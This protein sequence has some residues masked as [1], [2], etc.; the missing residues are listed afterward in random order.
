MEK[1]IIKFG[2]IKIQ[3]Q[4]FHQHKR[5]VSIKNVDVNKIVLSNKVSFGK[6]RFKYVT[7]YKDAKKTKP[8]CIFLPKMSAYRKN[9]NETKYM[10]FSIKDDKLLEKY[11]EIWEKVKNIIRKEFDSEAVYNEKYLKARIKSYKGKFN[12]NFQNNKIPKESSQFICLSV[13]LIDS[14]WTVFRK[15]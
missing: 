9:F 3:K 15:V 4:K 7:G 14:V 6:K 12:T 10:S 8:L 1:T 11:N 2:D 5:P 13:I